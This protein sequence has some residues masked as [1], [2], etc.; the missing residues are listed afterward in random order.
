MAGRKSMNNV[1]FTGFVSTRG[2]LRRAHTRGGGCL[3]GGTLL[4]LL[5]LCFSKSSQTRLAPTAQHISRPQT[6][7]RSI[8]SIP[9]AS[10]LPR[11]PLYTQ[12]TRTRRI[13]KSTLLALHSPLAL[14]PNASRGD[15]LK[16]QLVPSTP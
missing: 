14:T 7:K 3:R 12:N 4:R 15:A 5:F 11:T 2:L 13:K 9:P 1:C 6:Y 16:R 8:R 10:S